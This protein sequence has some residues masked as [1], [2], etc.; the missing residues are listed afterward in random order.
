[1]LEEAWKTVHCNDPSLWSH[2]NFSP[3]L[4]TPKSHYVTHNIECNQAMVFLKLLLSLLNADDDTTCLLIIHSAAMKAAWRG[5][6]SN[7]IAIILS[8]MIEEI[9]DHIPGTFALGDFSVDPD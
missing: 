4:P 7:S 3:N 2:E 1:V 5:P 8:S 6:S 9:G